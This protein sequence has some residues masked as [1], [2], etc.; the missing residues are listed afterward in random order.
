M[1]LITSWY[2]Y[3]IDTRWCGYWLSSTCSATNT[4]PLISP[5]LSGAEQA[6][7]GWSEWLHREEKSRQGN[8]GVGLRSPGSATCSVSF[9]P[10]KIF[11]YNITIMS[12]W[13]IRE[14]DFSFCGW[15]WKEHEHENNELR[16]KGRES[17]VI[18]QR[19]PC[20]TETENPCRKNA[21]CPTSH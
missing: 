10:K 20:F 14:Q 16:N 21:P 2:C 4:S 7:A 17:K 3:R 1:L 12:H 11:Q 15:F 5:S 6:P 13:N 18:P 8:F 9:I 19:E